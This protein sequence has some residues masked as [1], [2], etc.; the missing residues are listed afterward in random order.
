MYLKDG[1][2]SNTYN[3]EELE[4]TK[5]LTK[6]NVLNE[7]WYEGLCAQEERFNMPNYH[8]ALGIYVQRS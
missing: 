5:C 2:Y 8:P 1:R 7:L 4:T 3:L 6:G